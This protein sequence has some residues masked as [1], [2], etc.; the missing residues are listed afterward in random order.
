[1]GGL[2]LRCWS[3]LF[4]RLCL[5]AHGR[6]TLS[7]CASLVAAAHFDFSITINKVCIYLLTFSSL[8]FLLCTLLPPLIMISL[9]GAPPALALL[10]LR[11]FHFF[12]SKTDAEQTKI[13]CLSDRSENLIFSFRQTLVPDKSRSD[14]QEKTALVV[15]YLSVCAFACKEPTTHSRR[16][17]E[18]ESATDRPSLKLLTPTYELCR[19]A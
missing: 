11:D 14:Y 16:V 19:S 12:Q 13:V 1:L 4:H 6:A 2:I 8:L 17:N 10:A 15:K 9:V 3:F 5:R 18:E 7:W